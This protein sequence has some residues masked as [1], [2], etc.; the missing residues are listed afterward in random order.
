MA[1]INDLVLNV[2]RQMAQK[3][4]TFRKNMAGILKDNYVEEHVAWARAFLTG[5]KL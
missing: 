5:K 2:E 3:V 1:S 4:F